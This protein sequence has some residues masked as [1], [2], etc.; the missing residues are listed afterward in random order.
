MKFIPTRRPLLYTPP[1]VGGGGGLGLQTNLGSFFSLDNT[2]ADATG[3]VTDLTNVNTVTFVS[4][5]G[6]LTAVTNAASFTAASSQR[7]THADATGINVAGIN[8]SVQVWVYPTSNTAAVIHKSSGGFGSREYYLRRLFAT[9]SSDPFRVNIND[10]SG[11]DLDTANNSPNAWHHI[12]LTYNATTNAAIL[13]LDG[14]SAD[15]D[16]AANDPAGT[17]ALSLGSDSTPANYFSGRMALFGTWRNRVL[18]A[19]DV[20]ALYNGGAGLSYA[21]MA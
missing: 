11:V 13:Y 9:G 1:V 4:P 2:L 21:A 15:T 18:S 3:A 10:G 20:T 14:A 19:A 5:G 12:V 7:L 6:T 8:F 17:S 16:T